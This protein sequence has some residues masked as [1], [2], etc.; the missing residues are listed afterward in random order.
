MAQVEILM[1]ADCQ[2]GQACLGSHPDAIERV[3]AAPRQV[4]QQGDRPE[5]SVESLDQ[6]VPAGESHRLRAG[7]LRRGGQP[8]GPD[9]IVGKDADACL[10]VHPV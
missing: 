1:L 4:D 6:R 8:R 2:D 10:A 5:W 3:E 7:L 9:E